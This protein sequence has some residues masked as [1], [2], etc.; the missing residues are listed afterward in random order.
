MLS[1]R[2]YGSRAPATPEW[3]LEV[4]F[5]SVKQQLGIRR[6]DTATRARL[7]LKADF[8]LRRMGEE[9]PVFKGSERSFVS[10]NILTDP[11]ATLAAEENATERGLVQLSDMMASRIALYLAGQQ[12]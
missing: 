9:E 11:Y 10:Y 3:R 2:F 7:T 4:G 12:Q 6:D 8:I 1:D 5:T